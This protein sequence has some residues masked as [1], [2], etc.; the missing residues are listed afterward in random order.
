MSV[1]GIKIVKLGFTQ[2]TLAF[3]LDV[4]NPN[5][6]NLPVNSL[7][8]VASSNNDFIAEGSNNQPVTL[9]ANNNTEVVVTVEA[10]LGKVLGKI[11]EQAGNK[12]PLL[13][14][15]VTGSIKLDN[16]PTRIPFNVDKTL[17]LDTVRASG[18]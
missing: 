10:S 3:T 9:T 16:W 17:S 8:F 4:F 5:A 7:D 6:F 1:A 18:S 15:N 2:Q 13:D 14:Y 11:L 12:E